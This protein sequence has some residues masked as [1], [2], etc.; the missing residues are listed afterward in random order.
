MKSIKLINNIYHDDF[1]KFNYKKIKNKKK[2]RQKVN[3]KLNN[4]KK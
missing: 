2:L 3:K 4:K 1:K